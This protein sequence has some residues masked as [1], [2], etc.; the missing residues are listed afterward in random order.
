MTILILDVG[1]SSVRALLF[2]D[3]AR[4]IPDA[5]ISRPVQ[6]TTDRD[7]ASTIRADTLLRKVELCVD[8]MLSHPEAEN[9]RAV[10]AAVFAGS[11]LGMDGKG[12]PLTPVLTYADT[13][14][15]EDVALLA[16]QVDARKLHQRTGVRLHTAYAPA[17][18]GWLLRTQT[19][20]FKKVALWGP[21][22]TYMYHAWFGTK[23]VSY[24]AAAW[25]GL[26]NR[27]TLKWDAEWR[28]FFKLSA[29]KL[30][31]LADY[32]DVQRG[33]LSDYA[34]RWP[35][36]AEVPFY[37]AVGDG[38]AANVGSGATSTSDNQR[39]PIALTV[40]TTAALRVVTTEALPALADG[41]WNYRIDAAHHLI[42]GAT[43]EG[44]SIF[45]W[46]RE[47]F[48]LP[49]E[50]DLE[51][52]IASREA[53]SHGLTFLPLLAGERAP[54]W[55]G[56]ATGTIHG[57][58]LSTTPLDLLH[59]ALEGVALRLAVIADQLDTVGGAP[60]FGGGGALSASPA[61]AQIICNALNRPLHL[62]AEPE[63]TARGVAILVLRAL[64]GLTLE[65]AVHSRFPP[66][67]ARMLTPDVTSAERYADA[68][69]RQAE[70]YVRLYAR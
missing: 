68:R 70:L 31:K 3:D 59:A 33:L 62:L 57:L 67:V 18:L 69:A 37:L 2:D 20:T 25:G 35:F 50:T 10:G 6:F 47:T 17:Q 41:L 19:A 12:K 14:S 30:P 16:G 63:I 22:A 23:V 8:D 60:V 28:D 54:G 40:G 65:E 13:R 44:G 34:L 39:S 58:R 32:D 61:W 5:I 56:D 42:G 38:A 53:D 4:P 15:H 66:Q 43:S 26:L 45:Q 64:D 46:A 7:G 51:A 55:R 24:S 52:E 49:D 21:F 9:I 29:K 27:E 11:L 48:A 36:L 1:S